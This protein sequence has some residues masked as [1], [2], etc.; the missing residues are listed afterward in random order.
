MNALPPTKVALVQH[1]QTAVYQGGHSWGKM[2]YVWLPGHAN[3]WWVDPNN[4]KI[5]WT[6]LPEASVLSRELLCY[7]CKKTALQGSASVALNC[8]ALCQF[9]G[10]C[11]V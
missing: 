8:T 1:I 3:W 9:G 11:D 2:L 4:W 10:E 6:T 5:L 7:G